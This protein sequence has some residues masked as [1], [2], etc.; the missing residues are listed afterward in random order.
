MP[1]LLATSTP[2]LMLPSRYATTTATICS[3]PASVGAASRPLVPGTPLH[4]AAANRYGEGMLWL[5]RPP[6]LRWLAAGAIVVAALAWDVAKSQSEPFPFASVAIG[7]GTAITAD[8]ITWKPVPDGAIPVPLLA[9]ATATANIDAGDPLTRSVIAQGSPLPEGWWS[10]P[11]DIPAGIPVGASIRVVLPDG[12]AA[13]GVVTEPASSDGYGV[14]SPGTVGFP[15]QVAD[16]VARLAATGNLVV[17]V[18]P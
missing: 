11:I 6:F 7:S 1:W 2:K 16:T 9:G 18:E 3:T 17:L 4:I 13:T 10:V 8:L 12:E 15:Q 5:S 14:P